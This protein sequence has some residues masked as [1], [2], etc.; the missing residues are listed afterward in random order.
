MGQSALAGAVVRLYVG[1]HHNSCEGASESSAVACEH[2]PD[3][4][5]TVANLLFADCH[6]AWHRGLYNPLAGACWCFVDE[7]S[8]MKSPKTKTS[9]SIV[10][11]AQTVSRFYL[12]SG[13][14]APN[15]EWE[16][17]M[18]LKAIDYYGVQQSYTRFKERYFTNIFFIY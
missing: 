1:C 4:R 5:N 3:C 15:G 2:R 6:A 14:P 12:L 11:Y 16:Y 17:Y 13:T 10:D 18:Q 7:S 8:S 9:K